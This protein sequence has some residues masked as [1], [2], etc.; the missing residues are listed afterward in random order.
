[1][2]IAIVIILAILWFLGFISIPALSTVPFVLL[3]HPIT[4]FDALVFLALIVLL[5]ILPGFFR[6]VAAVLLLLMV[7]SFFGL[8]AIA[9]FTSVIVLVTIF[10]I[11][12]YLITG[13]A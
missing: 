5:G 11:I 13:G 8:I 3:G 2:L 1:M 12:Y 7:L 4:V 9:N 6:F 10:A